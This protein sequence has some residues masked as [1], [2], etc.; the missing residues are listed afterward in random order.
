MLKGKN[1]QSE[2]AKQLSISRRAVQNIWKKYL[3]NG[4]TDDLPKSG[5]PSKNEEKSVRRIL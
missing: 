4:T 1:S 3:E 2:V 5:R